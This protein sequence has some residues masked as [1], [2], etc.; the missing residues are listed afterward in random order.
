[1]KRWILAGLLLTTGCASVQ[2]QREELDHC[3]VRA[4]LLARQGYASNGQEVKILINSCMGDA[5]WQTT[6]EGQNIIVKLNAWK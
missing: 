1:M 6:D 2:Q 3:T 4:L 5:Q